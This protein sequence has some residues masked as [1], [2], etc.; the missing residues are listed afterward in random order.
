MDGGID[1]D[2]CEIKNVPSINNVQK[3]KVHERPV[4]RLIGHAPLL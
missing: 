1:A 4:L 2:L 3:I